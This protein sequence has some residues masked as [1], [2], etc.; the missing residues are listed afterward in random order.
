MIGKNLL[1]SV[2]TLIFLLL[3]FYS[4]AQASNDFNGSKAD[5]DS[6][7]RTGDAI[8]AAFSRGDVNAILL[9]H[10]ADVIKA[11]NYPDFQKGKETLRNQL[12]GTLDSFH[13]EFV[14]NKIESMFIN[15]GTAVEQTLFTIKGIPKGRGKPFTFKGRSMIV[16]VKYKGSPTGWA[17]IREMIQPSTEK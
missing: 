15:G 5:R 13:L 11:L 4:Y 3:S 12:K 6:L 16:Y 17:T 10:H 8:R 9:Y 2:L 1:G 7:R 14:E